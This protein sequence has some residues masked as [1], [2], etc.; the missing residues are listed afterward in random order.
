[1][2]ATGL[3]AFDKSAKLARAHHFEVKI[4]TPDENA[5]AE[6]AMKAL[7]ASVRARFER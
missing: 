7:G 6:A 3:E 2:A 4:E 5:R 1:M